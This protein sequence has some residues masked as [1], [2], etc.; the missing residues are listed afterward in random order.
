MKIGKVGYIYALFLLVIAVPLITLT[1]LQAWGDWYDDAFITY[2]YADNL[3]S[4]AGLVWN[5]GEPPTEGFTSIMHVLALTPLMKLG[6]SGLEAARWVNVAFLLATAFVLYR[7][8]IRLVPLGGASALT[9]SVVFLLIPSSILLVMVGLETPIYTF[10]LLI[11]VILSAR[12]LNLESSQSWALPIA[13]PLVWFLLI[14]ARPEGGLVILATWIVA[15]L[16]V[17]Q[18]GKGSLRQLIRGTLIFIF[19][20]GLYLIWKW[21]FFGHLLPNPFYIKSSGTGLSP[22][23]VNSIF[24][25]LDLYAGF[26]AIA[27][28]SIALIFS[29]KADALLSRTSIDKNLIKI[30]AA[31]VILNVL[32]YARTDTL[33]DIN[34]RFLYP[35]LPLVILMSAPLITLGAERVLSVRNR[36]V[37]ISMVSLGIAIIFLSGANWNSLR[38]A[39]SPSTF[40]NSLN[41]ERVE[42]DNNVQL[43]LARTLSEYPQITKTKIAY[44]DAGVIPYL[45]RAPWVDPVGLNDTFLARSKNLDDSAKYLFGQEPN[46]IL[47]PVDETNEPINFGHGLLGNY[48]AWADDERWADYKVLGTF[49]RGDTPYSLQ[50]WVRQQTPLTDSLTDFLL[51]RILPG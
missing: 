50:V 13:L 20:G 6:M 40:I 35:L 32:F 37:P 41:A 29:G 18:R 36:F 14:L 23:G 15:L 16:A 12:V 48:A 1:G 4:G 7:L 5:A 31:V 47:I 34:G 42:L 11:A 44:G 25:F 27:L 22:L 49:I 10:L 26:I 19:L 38:T 8:S 24:T 2:R 9:I 30:S 45:T 33:M 21:N 28:A 43:G 51:N 3:A 39:Y 46:L 17:R